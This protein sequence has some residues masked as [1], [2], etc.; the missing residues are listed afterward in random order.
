MAKQSLDGRNLSSGAELKIKLGRQVGFK[1]W[2]SLNE[3]T[4]FHLVSNKEL[5]KVKAE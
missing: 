4:E 5:L 3:E 2:K 1:L